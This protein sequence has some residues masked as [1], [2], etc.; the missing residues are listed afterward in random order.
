QRASPLLACRQRRVL[1]GGRR[2]AGHTTRWRHATRAAVPPTL[3]CAY[4]LPLS[5]SSSLL[6]PIQPRLGDTTAVV[7]GEVVGVVL[8]IRL[9]GTGDHHREQIYIVLLLRSIALKVGQELL[10]RLRILGAPL[11]LRHGR[12]LG[13]VDMAA[14]A[15]LV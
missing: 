7:E 4:I 2:Q 8:Q 15:R 5:L 11:L 6:L 1:Q 13:I 14:V 10:A 3:S 12:K 9:P